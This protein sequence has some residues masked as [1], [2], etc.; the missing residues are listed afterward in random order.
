MLQRSTRL[1]RTAVSKQH[2]RR[3]YS[4]PSFDRNELDTQKID[5]KHYVNFKH[6]MVYNYT[7]EEIDVENV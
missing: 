7:K 1:L 4:V 3:L 6:E 5:Y 2:C